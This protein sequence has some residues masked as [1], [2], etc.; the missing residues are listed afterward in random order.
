MPLAICAL[1]RYNNRENGHY[2]TEEEI[3]VTSRK[4]QGNG[5][6]R[7]KLLALLLAMLLGCLIILGYCVLQDDREPSEGTQPSQT[8]PAQSSEEPTGELSSQPPES[9]EE[10]TQ[11]PTEGTSEPTQATEP[12]ATEPPVTEPSATEPTVAPTATPTPKPTTA[13]T[14]APSEAPSEAPEI[15]QEILLVLVNPTH[16][17]PEDWTVDLVQLR[18]GQAIDRRAYPSLQKM[19]DDCRA[20]GLDPVICSSYRTWQ[21]QE[22]LYE[23]RVKRW[24]NEHP[25]CTEQEARDGAAFWVARPGTSEHQLGFAV[26]IVSYSNWNLDSSQEKTA[27]QQWLMQ[28]SWR[29]GWILR[30]P[31]NKSD[32]TKIGYEPWH[33]RYVGVEAAKEIYESGLCLEEYLGIL[34]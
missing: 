17:V 25:G 21:T 33:Y 28:N 18:N 13:P 34:D 24:K 8:E 6:N 30:Y 4:K 31:T 19:M 11:T 23:N 15:P 1:S 10:P 16:L 27:T 12:P 32:I 14:T 20:A 2:R 5:R 3:C 9:S 26:D 7:L 29:Y 22:T